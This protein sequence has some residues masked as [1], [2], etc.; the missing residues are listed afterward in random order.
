MGTKM[1]VDKDGIQLKSWVLK[2]PNVFSKTLFKEAATRFGYSSDKRTFQKYVNKVRKREFN[3]T[4][5]R[6]NLYTREDR[7]D[8]IPLFLEELKK[9]PFIKKEELCDSLNIPPTKLADLFNECKGKGHELAWEDKYI[10]YSAKFPMEVPRL[11]EPLELKEIRYLT[12]TDPHFASKACQISAINEFFEFAY[13]KENI[14]Y[15]FSAG[16]MIA[17]RDVYKG[18]LLD[19]YAVNID[20]QIK[21][22][23]V[24]LPQKPDF[25][26]HII[27]GN[28]DYSAFKAIGYNP[29]AEL[30]R[31]RPDI[32]YW[33]FDKAILPLLPGVDM[34]VWHPSGGPAYAVSYKLQKG[35]ETLIAQEL[36]KIISGR[37]EKPT[38]RFFL[39]GH[40]HRQFQMSAASGE[41]FCAA[42]GSFE[43]VNS[44]TKRAGWDT[45]VGGYIIKANLN[46]QHEMRFR[47]FE[48]KWYPFGDEGEVWKQ[49]KHE[50]PE[51]DKIITPIF[52]E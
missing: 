37:K 20:D 27:G 15:G 48:A 42:C 17:G 21:S 44:L 18:Q 10:R 11:I 9:N 22:L 23:V 2:N 4:G 6:H 1:Y 29:L 33:G 14:R 40:I 24:N 49:Y 34:M 5:V 16:D 41:I 43:G 31:Q 26:W 28:H 7:P 8:L 51:E 39:M 32:H 3:K 50:L 36:G 30:K 52:E 45:V 38:I 12:L 46:K 35:I 25:E 47:D 13:H 19:L